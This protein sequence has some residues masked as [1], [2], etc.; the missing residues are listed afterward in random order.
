MDAPFFSVKR[1]GDRFETRGVTSSLL[2]HR[3]ENGRGDRD[4]VFG[5]WNWNGRQL[6]VSNDP[7]GFCPLFYGFRPGREISVSPS[8]IKLIDEGVA[9]DLDEVA[10]AVFLRLGF[11]IGEDT[12]FRFIRA[13]PPNARLEWKEGE[14][15]VHGGRPSNRAVDLS[16]EA[17]IDGYISLFRNA[18]HK[19][20]TKD[21]TFAI[22]LSGGRDSRHILLEVIKGGYRPKFCVT[23]RYY[24]P[25]TDEEATI[26]GKL[27]TA[28]G[29]PHIVLK[30]DHPWLYTEARK[31]IETNFLTDEDGW[32][33]A[34]ADYVKG[35]VEYLYDGIGGDVLSAGLFLDYE[36][37]SL[38]DG[39]RFAELARRLLCQDN[40][41][42]FAVKERT[43]RDLFGAGQ[44][45]RWSL[46]SA[47]AHLTE[48]IRVHSEAANPVGSF[49]FYNRTR[50]EIGAHAFSILGQG[51]TI[52]APYLDCELYEFLSAIPATVLLSHELHSET[53]RRAFPQYAG[54]PFENKSV[55]WGGPKPPYPTYAA[56][57]LYYMLKSKT[58]GGKLMRSSY[59]I[60]RLLACLAT[61]KYKG[62]W[63]H[64]SL[65]L[66]LFQLDM[67]RNR[68]LGN[69]RVEP[70]CGVRLSFA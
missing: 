13:L 56:D 3:V 33:L 61:R 24:W 26:A 30:Q 19:R 28:L 62:W 58:F 43:L 31:N 36:R 5:E 47:I 44:Y 2:G 53:I 20:E 59:L 16:R 15:S 37:L 17:I 49:F 57:V 41:G 23:A 38:F 63:P 45:S 6:V 64:P 4:G 70:S 18:I 25:T 27:A 54:I 14:L 8:I 51:A 46:E 42:R 48:E 52:L 39:G 10:L 9:T 11:F 32:L 22:P 65:F 29:L 7:L 50:R 35:R 40:F 60:P 67:F 34:L 69:H 55:T 1:V 68:T 66:Y 12:P 21:G